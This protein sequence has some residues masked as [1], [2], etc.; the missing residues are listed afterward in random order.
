MD[1]DNQGQ[2]LDGMK[3]ADS[4]PP[5]SGM[6]GFVAPNRSFD[7]KQQDETQED[8]PMQQRESP[9]QQSAA[10]GKSAGVWIVILII[11]FIIAA[12]A[13]GYF[14][15]QYSKT[16]TDLKTAQQTSAQSATYKQQADTL[17]KQNAELQKTATAQTAYIDSLVKVAGQLKTTCG[18][19]CDK[20]VI[21]TAPTAIV[22]P[23]PT[24]S[25]TPKPTVTVTPTPKATP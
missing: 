22:T 2:S 6:D 13:A 15:M 3:P 1:Q 9:V 12:G 17:T 23:T 5:V 10:G 24:P 19:T 7:D 14:Y 8:Q 21:P 20:I 18:K 4:Q 25:T 16:K 11:L